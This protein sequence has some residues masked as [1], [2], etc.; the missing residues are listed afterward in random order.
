MV[1][2]GTARAA[3]AQAKLDPT[4]VASRLTA[5]QTTMNQ[6]GGQAQQDAA[7]V[8]GTVRG[9]LNQYGVCGNFAN[10][11][12]AFGNELA[13]KARKYEGA[14]FTAE[15]GLVVAKW[16]LRCT[17]GGSIPATFVSILTAICNEYGV[18]YA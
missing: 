18:T 4:I 2:D 5:Q 8:A 17:I 9:I 1:K 6:R 10:T 15:A 3:K 11:F 7:D 13:A 14:A 16:K 12:Q